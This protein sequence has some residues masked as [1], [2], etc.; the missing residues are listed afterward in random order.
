MS[1]QLELYKNKIPTIS[2][3]YGD[4]DGIT[5]N[6]ALAVL[7]NSAPLP[8]WIK[9]HPITKINYIP[10]GR[11]EYLL[12]RI[13][14]KWRSEIKDSKILAN[15][16]SVTVRLWYIDPITGEWDWSDGIGA[17]PLQTDQGKGA[18]DFNYIKSSAV[19]MAA[20][21]AESLAIKDAAEKLGKIF[22]KDISRKDVI[23]Y[24]GLSEINEKRFKNLD[25]V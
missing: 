21:A 11:I 7:L 10:I 24:D 2:E 15:S 12:T 18:I 14:G 23:N 22:G 4:K 9:I 3:L 25:D 20:P 17:A 13:F 5:K 19:M 16:I 1:N 6:T 8:A